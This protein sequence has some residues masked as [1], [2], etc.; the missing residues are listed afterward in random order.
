VRGVE[1][2]QGRPWMWRALPGGSP[3]RC[4]SMQQGES[5]SRGENKSGLISETEA[6][7]A[8]APGSAPSSSAGCPFAAPFQAACSGNG[9]R[10]ENRRLN[11][12]PA[13]KGPSWLQWRAS[14][15]NGAVAE[16]SNAT[17]TAANGRLGRP[18]PPGQEE[19]G[20]RSSLAP[21][22]SLAPAP[23]PHAPHSRPRTCSG[24]QPAAAERARV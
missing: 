14:P 17:T 23:R 20:P 18:S 9:P 12:P 2:G 13:A 11:Q 1:I 15:A 3:C 6:E 7:I 21:G 19:L 4:V 16:M 5:A 22:K 8:A 10:C 24:A